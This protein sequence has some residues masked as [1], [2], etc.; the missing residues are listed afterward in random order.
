MRRLANTTEA[1][2]SKKDT[3]GRALATVVTVCLN[4]VDA[5]DDDGEDRPARLSLLRRFVRGPHFYGRLQKVGIGVRGGVVAA[6]PAAWPK[7]H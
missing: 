2:L 7:M 4:A 5:M 1:C 6:Q 3:A